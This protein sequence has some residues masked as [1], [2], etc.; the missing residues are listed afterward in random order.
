MDGEHFPP[1][2]SN[3]KK[4]KLVKFLQTLPYD[5]QCIIFHVDMVGEGID[6]PGITGV[7]PFR[8]CEESKFLQNVGR[9]SRL[10]LIDRPRI[11]SGEI[12]TADRTKWVK[13]CSWVIVP[14]FLENAEGFY[15]R[16][17][18]YI[19]RLKDDFGY[20]PAQQTVIEN[21]RGLDEDEPIDPVNERAKN[22][23]HT[24]SGLR[25]FE[26]EFE[27]TRSIT[28]QIIFEDN[29]NAEYAKAKDEFAQLIGAEDKVPA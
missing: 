16:F 15:A 12:S 4:H 21:V 5:E 10:H 27:D 29:I 6:V 9:T 8:N 14:T 22:R 1:P 26:H 3:I 28:E 11:Y 17:K 25:K 24:N 2:V 19:Q 20:I 7:M 18:G 13:P 23:A